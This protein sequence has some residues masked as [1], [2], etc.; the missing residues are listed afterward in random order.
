LGPVSIINT[1]SQQWKALVEASSAPE[2]PPEVTAMDPFMLTFTSG[3]SGD[4]KAVRVGNFTVTLSG[5]NL[6]QHLDLTSYDV[7]YLSMPRL[8]SN[9]F[10]GGFSPAIAVGAT[11][12]LARR[13]SASRFGDDIRRYGVTYMNYVGKPLAYILDTPPRPDD[14]DT[15]LRAAFGNEAAAKDIPA[16]AE[17]F[18]CRVWDAYGSTELAIII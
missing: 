11:M 12:A 16:F 7:L 9:A 6:A 5:E 18:G 3:T 15:P 8:R 13:F 14:A 4:P 17:R 10:M 2:D 1:D